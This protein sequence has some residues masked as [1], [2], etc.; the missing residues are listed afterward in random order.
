MKTAL[1]QQIDGAEFE[2]ARLLANEENTSVLDSLDSVHP[3]IY[4]AKTPSMNFLKAK[5]RHL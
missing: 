3:A 1:E 4:I 2:N 5:L